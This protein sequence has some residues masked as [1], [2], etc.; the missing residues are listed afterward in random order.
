MWSR[1]QALLP[2]LDAGVTIRRVALFRRGRK[3]DPHSESLA[4]SVPA[5]ATV[6]SAR[7]ATRTSQDVNSSSEV[8]EV[9]LDVH[10]ADGGEPTRH[11]VQWT[12]FAVAVPAVQAGSKLTVRVDPERPAIVYPPGYPPPGSKPGVISLGDARILPTSSWLDSHL[13]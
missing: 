13:A 4:R 7:Q 6:V 1:R 12:V 9:V 10:S 2:P 3:S 8:Y 5:P 11:T